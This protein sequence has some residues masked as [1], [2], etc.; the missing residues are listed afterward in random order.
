[1][2]A[3]S[4]NVS[5][6][7]FDCARASN[8]TERAICASPRLSELDEYLARY[9]AAARMALGHAEACLRADQQEWLHRRNQCAGP[10][11]I[12][13]A[14][15]DR[16]A[17]LDPLQPGA[18][19]LRKETLPERPGLVWI[20]PPAADKVAAPANPKAVRG[21]LR[22]VLLDEVADGDGFVVRSASGERRLVVP[23]MFLEA[24]TAERLSALAREPD[25]TFMASGHVATDGGRRDFE[26]SRCTFVHRENAPLEGRIFPGPAPHPGFKPHELAF[27]TPRDGVARA[28]FRSVPF[29]AVILRTAARCSVKEAERREVQALFPSRKVFFPRSG[30]DDSP[31][32]NIAYTNVDD[33]FAFLAVYAGATE[34]EAREFLKQVKALGRFPG[35]NVRRMQAV[36]LYP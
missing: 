3:A 22:G 14:Y 2:L 5:A 33:K 16:L 25:V 31:E 36:L 10:G 24:A 12:E 11:C 35:A 19:A 30:C 7:G 29:H 13:N 26:P 18:T 9:Y 1:M 15:M 6:A 27:A 23:L 28:E 17:E 4:A 8:A 20:V 34:P 21:F 32:E